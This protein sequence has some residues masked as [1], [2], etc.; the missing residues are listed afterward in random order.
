MVKNDKLV[1]G[2][3]QLANVAICLSALRRAV[4]RPSH[5]PGLV[6]FYGPSG[7]G[8]TSAAA[9]A[10][11]VHRAY[12]VEAKSLWTRKALLVAVLKEMGVTPATTMAE[13]GDQVSEQLALSG[14]PLIVDEMDHVVAKGAVEVIRDIYEGSGAAILLIGEEGLPHKLREWERFHGR[15]L[16]W[17]PAQPAD[18]EDARA[19]RDLY[20]DRV[21][22]ED[23]LVEHLQAAAGGSV[24][25]IAV[26]LERVQEEAAKMG[27]AA[28]G[29]EE[30]GDRPLFTGEPP[31]R[32]VA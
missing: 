9:V 13:M 31:R 23:D 24:R 3:A 21:Q 12:Y 27:L 32:R 29:L 10:A 14:R 7:W 16:D 22:V 11:N 17:V 6:C 25:R 20:C 19:L 5:L 1:N 26:N 15:V 30:W 18:I 28:I 2:V 8:K 4:E